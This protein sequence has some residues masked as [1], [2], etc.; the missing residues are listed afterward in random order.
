[1]KKSIITLV[2]LL[3][4]QTFYG[5]SDD[6]I[7]NNAKQARTLSQRWELNKKNDRGTFLIT[8]YKPIYMTLA[9]WCDSPNKKPMNTNPANGTPRFKD[10]SHFEADFQVSFKT[11]VLQDAIFG[12]GDLWVAFTQN[13]V[14][15]VYTPDES[16]PFRELNYEPEIIFNVP[17]NWSIDRFNLRMAGIGI[18]HQSNGRE[19]SLSRS[20]N[21]IIFQFGMTYD[22][23]TLMLRPWI[24]LPE[25][26]GVDDNYD[27]YKYMGYGDANLIYTKKGYVLSLLIRN[28]LNFSDNKGYLGFSWAFPL[29]GNLKFLLQA[30]HGY[31]DTLIDYNHKQTYIGVGFSLIEWL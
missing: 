30:S 4:A 26:R 28:N 31:G 8:P 20:W 22:N 7:F 12:V 18:N 6:V 9:R 15:Q 27:I 14:W 16:R 17:L 1:M 19:A 23:F 3:I 11:K 13:A 5:Q 29:K 2:F 24:R 10:W 25:D 21:R